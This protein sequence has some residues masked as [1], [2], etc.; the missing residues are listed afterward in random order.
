MVIFYYLLIDKIVSVI[1]SKVTTIN[2]AEYLL[3]VVITNLGQPLAGFD[4]TVTLTT[5]WKL[6]KRDSSQLI[7][8]DFISTK[9]TA[10]VGDA[11]AAVKR[12][13]LANE[14]AARKNIGKGKTIVNPLCSRGA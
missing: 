6:S 3:N 1:F 8:Q 9:Y 12:L 7:W 11:F 13:R 14:G 10:T 4:M 5:H 2:G